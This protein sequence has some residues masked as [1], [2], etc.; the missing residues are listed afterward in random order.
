MHDLIRKILGLK[1]ADQKYNQYFLAKSKLHDLDEQLNELSREFTVKNELQKSI[2][3]TDIY[4][5]E[6]KDRVREKFA[7]FLKS[8]SEQLHDVL[9]QRNVFLEKRKNLESDPALVFQ[10]LK[11][12]M[13]TG[14]IAPEMYLQ[15]QYNIEKA[16]NPKNKVAQVMREYESGKLRSSSGDKVTS[17]DQAVA[18]AMSEAGISKSDI[19]KADPCWSGY[20]M[21]GMKKKDGKEV[22]NCVKKSEHED[23]EVKKACPEHVAKADGCPDKKMSINNAE[24]LKKAVSQYKE[25]PDKMKAAMKA[26]IVSR[27]LTL[28]E[29][30]A[31]PAEWDMMR[32]ANGDNEPKVKEMAMTKG[33]EKEERH[34]PGETKKEYET[35]EKKESPEREKKEHAPGGY[36][37]KPA[38]SKEEFQ[39]KEKQFE[40]E[41]PELKKGND[42]ISEQH[43]KDMIAEHERLIPL[44]ER[45]SNDSEVAKELATQKKELAR[46]SGMLEKADYYHPKDATA[47]NGDKKE[48]DRDFLNKGFE[49]VGYNVDSEGTIDQLDFECNLESDLEKAE[50]QGKDVTLGKP[51]KGD[52]KKYKVYVKNAKGNVVK[53][54]FGDPNMEIKRDDPERRR[55]FR[56]R[57]KCDQ[58]KDRTSAGYWSCK[59]WSKTPVSQMT[60]ALDCLEIAKDLGEIDEFEYNTWIQKAKAGTYADNEMNRRLGRVGE[61][62]GKADE[63]EEENDKKEQPKAAPKEEKPEK[64]PDERPI[65]VKDPKEEMPSKPKKVTALNQK[66]PRI[67]KLLEQAR[68]TSK[69]NLEGAVNQSEDSELRAVAQQELERRKMEENVPP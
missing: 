25:C 60:K 61:K 26:Y 23:E 39:R 8:Y 16:K 29:T 58:Q 3:S 64:E 31:L 51:M 37:E 44:L 38:K 14:G 9:D 10:D 50:H 54:E 2:C 4:E 13:L 46:Y 12:A 17:R 66:D 24:D 47:V 35:H 68:K 1:T 55:S 36:E 15:I 69:K 7:E 57:H 63:D 48:E 42:G 62:Y 27:A 30:V 65:V 19:D 52:V 22:P 43:L 59:M 5:D 34:Y 49:L 6:V 28:G 20:E 40:Q 56:A 11:K 53:V 18:I 45:F 41:N 21:V 33:G 67:K 32:K